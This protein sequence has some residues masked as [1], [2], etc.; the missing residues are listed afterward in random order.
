MADEEKYAF[1]RTAVSGLMQIALCAG[2]CNSS[3]KVFISIVPLGLNNFKLKPQLS[4]V[5]RMT[6][7]FLGTSMY[8]S[9][10]TC[11]TG[12]L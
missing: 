11:T 4:S 7:L 10:G 12:V 2:L 9:P 3:F 8:P 1:S 5:G 6:E